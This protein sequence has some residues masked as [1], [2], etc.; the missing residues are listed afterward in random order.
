MTTEN[1]KTP[2]TA[3]KDSLP[4]TACSERL[5]P[6]PFCGGQVELHYTI[7]G[8]KPRPKDDT[9]I[10]CDNCEGLDF[11]ADTIEEAI[12]AWNARAQNE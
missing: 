10:T 4:A 1:Q 2:E 7:P 8:H 12:A 3:V 9:H 6:C 11:Y 5:L